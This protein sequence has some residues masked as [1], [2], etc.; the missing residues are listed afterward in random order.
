[1]ESNSAPVLSGAICGMVVQDDRRAEHD[2]GVAR[3]APASTGQQRCWRQRRPPRPPRPA[4]RSP[5]RTAPRRRSISRW[6]PIRDRRS[7]ASL[8]RRPAGRDVVDAD[9][10]PVA[11]RRSA[12]AAPVTRP[13]P[14]SAA[15]TRLRRP[16]ARG[17]ASSARR[18][19]RPRRHGPS[20]V[21]RAAARQR[22]SGSRSISTASSQVIQ[23]SPSTRSSGTVDE[24]AVAIEPLGPAAAAAAG[25]ARWIGDLA[26]SRRSSREQAL[27]RQPRLLAE[28]GRSAAPGGPS[29]P[30]CQ[31][32]WFLPRWRGTGRA[33][34]PRRARRR[35]PPGPD[36]GSWSSQHP[37]S[38]EQVR[39]R[40]SSQV[41]RPCVAL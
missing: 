13:A 38:G 29:T 35:R 27:H 20:G 25:S 16:A 1:M 14:A 28:P 19:R 22:G 26:A 33:G 39:R 5:R 12:P 6:V 9:G 18:P 2:V 31:R 24:A 34:S 37:I 30:N 15:R 36:R 7:A 32:T 21:R 23:R 17:R 3:R 4:G 41:V 10:Q 8:V 11:S 40:P